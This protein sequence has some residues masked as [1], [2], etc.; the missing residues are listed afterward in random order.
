MGDVGRER[1]RRRR[2]NGLSSE[3]LD[4]DLGIS[5]DE[6]VLEGIVVVGR[7]LGSRERPSKS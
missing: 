6:Q 2:T 4:E 5:V 7:R 3:T 1:R